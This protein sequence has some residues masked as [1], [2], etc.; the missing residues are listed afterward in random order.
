MALINCP[1]C[2]R[3]VSSNAPACPGCG[4]PIANRATV[5]EK[6]SLIP[7]SDQEVAVMLSRKKKTSHI[8]HLFLSVI[9]M[10]LWVVVWIIVALS[11]SME[12]SRIDKMINNGKRVR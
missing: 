7:Y 10:G 2:N 12:N 1:D 9:T 5:A 8:L 11:N 3:E 4:S 6:G